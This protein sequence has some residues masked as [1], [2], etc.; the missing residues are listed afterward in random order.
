MVY[1]GRKNRLRVVKTVAFGVY[2][3]GGESGEILLPRRDVPD[4]CKPGDWLHVFIYNDSDD[5]LIAT[6]ET[7]AAMVGECAYLMV[8]QQNDVG[9]FLDW[10]L[11]KDLLVPF[12]E[13]A[14]P[15]HQGRS[16]VVCVYLD[17]D[18]KRIAASTKYSRHLS[19]DGSG[20]TPG[21]EVKLMIAAT[22]ELGYKAVINNSHLGLIFKADV[23]QPLKFGQQLRGYIK[24]IRDDGKIDLALQPA[25]AEVVDQ[26][27]GAIL[28]YMRHNG[29]VSRIT[30]KSP[31][32]LIYK[33]FKA[34]KANYKR[35][36]GRLYKKRRISI[37]KYQIVLV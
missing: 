32:D 2:L 26:L 20:F 13:Q 14:W 9:T 23:F 34:S 37:E 22:T 4:G 36:L 35:A 25:S 30:D 18:T 1:V 24:T 11:S 31:P 10:G 16:Y 6:R 12:N 3:D 21:D 8:R 19:E 17:E 15:M 7:P 29:G 28:D 33:T 5:R 27:E